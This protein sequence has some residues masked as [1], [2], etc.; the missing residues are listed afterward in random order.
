MK[1]I[2]GI[3]T[4]PRANWNTAALVQTALQG[5]EDTGAETEMINLY[6]LEPFMGCR[7]CFGCMTEKHYDACIIKDGLTE[8]L[9]KLRAADGI[10]LGSPVYFGRFTAGYF[11]LTERLCFQH[12]TYR[13]EGFSSNEHPVPVL[14]IADSNHP[15]EGYEEVGLDK[16]I[17][18]CASTL[19]ML[20]GPVTTFAV[21]NTLQVSDYSRF[22]WTFF[23]PEDRQRHHDEVFPKELAELR[24]LSAEVF[25]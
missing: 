19:E 8:T 16:E 10:I 14:L 6:Q 18:H 7:S 22:N 3:N 21:G 12:L 4:S 11:A 25:K 17:A 13:I 1:K 20:I 15:R 5:A 23:D 9:E 24:Q 2:V